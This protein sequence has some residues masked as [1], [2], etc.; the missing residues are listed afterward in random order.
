MKRIDYFL[1]RPDKKNQM[2]LIF[3]KVSQRNLKLVMEF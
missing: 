2:Y 1:V 3:K